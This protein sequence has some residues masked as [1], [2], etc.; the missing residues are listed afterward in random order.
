LVLAARVEQVGKDHARVVDVDE[1]LTGSAY[2]LGDFLHPQCVRSIKF[3][4]YCRSHVSS[5]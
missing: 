4:Q 1:Q 5:D 2:G 3:V